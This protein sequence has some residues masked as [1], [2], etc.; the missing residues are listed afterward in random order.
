MA[1]GFTLNKE[2]LENFR[3]FIRQ[4]FLKNNLYSDLSEKYD[5]EISSAAFKKDFFDDIKKIGPFGTGNPLP[6]FLF[7]DLKVIKTKIL[8]RK[9]I[10]LLLKSKIGYSINPDSPDSFTE[11]L[12]HLADNPLIVDK[13]GINSRKIAEQKFSSKLISLTIF[14][15]SW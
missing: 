11:A 7:K 12:I 5:A 15:I 9:H 4:D 6:T 2:N 10:S 8:K 1:G 3:E 13:L 14:L